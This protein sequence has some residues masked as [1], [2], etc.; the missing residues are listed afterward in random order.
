M[1]LYRITIVDPHEGTCYVWAHTRTL[2]K[3]R[4]REIVRNMATDTKV[5]PAMVEEI[6]IGNSSE[7]LAEW[8]NRPYGWTRDNG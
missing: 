3:E 5:T 8:L 1:K 7:A 4:A 6:R 2:V